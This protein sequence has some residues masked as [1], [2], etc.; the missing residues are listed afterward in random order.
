M[1]RTT[2]RRHGPIVLSGSTARRR[3]RPPTRAE[4]LGKDMLDTPLPGKL[5]VLLSRLHRSEGGER[6]R[7]QAS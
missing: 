2:S 7:N 3:T 1:T 6:D 4:L 5:L